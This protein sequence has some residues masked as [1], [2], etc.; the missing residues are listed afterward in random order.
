MSRLKDRSVKS[1]I[2]KQ[3]RSDKDLNL[4][5]R[6]L[7]EKQFKVAHQKLLNDFNSHAITR[8][9]RVGEGSPNYSG[10]LREGNLFGFIGF[11]SGFDPISPIERLLVKANILIKQRKVMRSGLTWAYAVNIASINDLY[12]ITPMPWATGSSWLRELEGR[13]IPNLGQYM[14]VDAKSS[15]STEGI[16]G[17]NRSGGRLRMEYMKPLLEEFQNNLNNISSAQRISARNF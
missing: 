4:Q 13:G 9:L 17:G 2:Q 5:I 10:G 1:S 8:E 11:E 7:I 3:L 6:V 15:R 14:Y 12:K 16:Q